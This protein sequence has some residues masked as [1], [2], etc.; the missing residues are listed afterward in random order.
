MSDVKNKQDPVQCSIDRTP[1]RKTTGK[2][3][4]KTKA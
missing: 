3:T 4:G 2:T 1:E